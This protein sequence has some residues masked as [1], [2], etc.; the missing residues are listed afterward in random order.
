MR[1]RRLR[2][3]RACHGQTDDGTRRS[4]QNR[5]WESPAGI[6]S[7]P[8]GLANIF[9]KKIRHLAE[10]PGSRTGFPLWDLGGPYLTRARRHALPL[11]W[12]LRR[13][14]S[15]YPRDHTLATLSY[16]KSK[17]LSWVTPYLPSHTWSAR[18]GPHCTYPLIPSWVTP[19]LL[20]IVLARET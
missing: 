5:G 13:P 4:V 2:V 18:P 10:G 6:G 20:P 17:N 8:G 3:L 9:R 11:L 15:A 14:H 1:H 12:G 7:S 19:S 16:P